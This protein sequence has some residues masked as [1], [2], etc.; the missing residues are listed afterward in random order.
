[1]IVGFPGETPADF[2]Q[3]LSLVREVRFE[4]MFSF[5][6]SA[7]PYT[8]AETWE[9]EVSELEKTRRLMMLQRLQKGL[10]LRLHEQ[11]YLGRRFE[12]LVE[13][14]ARDG[15][16]SFG[17]TTSNKVVNF[18]G[19]PPPGSFVEILVTQVGPNSFV[20]RRLEES[21]KNCA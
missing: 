18:P 20:G 3:T 11:H 2:E 12:I 21:I 10:Q 16:Q 17:R 4:S 5:K 8:E 7:R 14:K 6:Y 1:M 19:T 9:T 15:R 13:G